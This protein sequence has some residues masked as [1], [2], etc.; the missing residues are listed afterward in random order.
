VWGFQKE[1]YEMRNIFSPNAAHGSIITSA[2]GRSAAAALFAAAAAFSVMAPLPARA[3]PSGGITCRITTY[4]KTAELEKEVGL[5]TTCPGVSKWGKT[6][7][8]YEVE[9]IDTH[10]DGPGGHDGP[11]GL[12]CEFLA[13][14]CSNLPQIRNQ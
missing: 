4:F 10:N 2:F 1:S 3:L 9:L 12:P 6:S 8:Y 7:K 11:G 14:G 13:E 5:R